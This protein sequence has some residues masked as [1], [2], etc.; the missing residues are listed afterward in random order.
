MARIRTIKPEFPQSETVGKLSRDARLMFIMLW[1]VADDEGRFRAASR[2][3]AS[4]LYPYDEDAG[5]L[6]EGWLDELEG[7]KCIRRYTVDGSTYGEITNWL[8]HQKIDKP[9]KSRLP[10][11]VEGS[12][13]PRE[14][15]RS[16][17]ADL[18]PRT[19]D[20][21]QGP[22]DADAG[23]RAAKAKPPSDVED[24]LMVIAMLPRLIS[25]FMA[26]MPE[27]AG[28]HP[29][30]A[31]EAAFHAAI[32]DG[33]DPHAIIDCAREYRSEAIRLGTAGTSE[34]T[35]ADTWLISRPWSSKAPACKRTAGYALAK[36]VASIA[37][38]AEDF[39]MTG[40]GGATQRAQVWL[41]AKGW[42]EESIL[43]SVREQAA[44]KPGPPNSI[45]YFEKGIAEHIARMS[46]PVPTVTLTTTGKSNAQQNSK[47]VIAAADR[48]IDRVRAM[49]S[50]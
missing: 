40:W 44:R 26:T 30:K 6:T 10:A 45:T 50:S 47:S 42:T 9:S 29:K 31:T 35:A 24:R 36:Q 14:C 28:G 27:R 22:I 4:L 43:A 7:A 32:R 49:R 12:P 20:L 37:G 13:K 23:A 3:L 1:T 2:M 18:G 8:K 16:L 11:F 21:D 15:S 38:R 19:K 48:L 34:I 46:A 41:D 25:E 17:A 39:E 33:Q 5:G